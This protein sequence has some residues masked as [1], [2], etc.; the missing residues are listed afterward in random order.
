MTITEFDDA[1]TIVAVTTIVDVDSEVIL[2][3]GD[4]IDFTQPRECRLGIRPG[5]TNVVG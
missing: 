1:V 5:E 3:S 4:A 2:G